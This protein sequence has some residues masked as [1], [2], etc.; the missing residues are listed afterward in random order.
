[1]KMYAQMGHGDGQK[2]ASGLAEGLIDGVILSPRD[3]R[4]DDI[5]SRIAELT[6]AKE[7]ADIFLDPQFYAT[8][9]ASSNAARIGKLPDW[10]YF[11]ALSRGDLELAAEVDRILRETMQRLV[12]I[13]L[14]GIIAPNIY[15]SRSFDSREGVIAKNFIRNA[16]QVY[17]ELGDAR[18]LF[19]TIAVSREALLERT[20]FEEF[21]ND[22]TMLSKPP[23]GFYL[24]IGSRS[25][26][27]RTDIF[28]AD[29]IA[30]WMLLNYSLRINGFRVINGYSDV[31]APFLGAVGG[32]AGATGWYSNLRVF[33]LDRFEPSPGGGRHAIKRYLST[34]LLNRITFIE[35]DALSTV[36]PSTTNNLAHDAAYNPEPD[37]RG[38]M[39]QSWE[40]LGDL[41]MRLALGDAEA[42]LNACNMA[43][44]SAEDA[45]SEIAEAGITLD[46]KSADSHLEPLREGI[47]TFKVMAG[48]A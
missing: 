26:E 38:E 14:N 21:L 47:Q 35:R 29:V 33:S 10:S 22:M 16:R 27:A 23:D 4:P 32:D 18:P 48:L 19:A 36:V 24:L 43:I 6:A 42:G 25:T 15:V 17:E 11:S 34:C 5:A 8:F 28:H 30:R 39:L 7:D 41:N 40:A 45:Y 37:S 2:A 9:A 1:M 12:G 20:E 31:V 3:W 44:S 13:P 46:R